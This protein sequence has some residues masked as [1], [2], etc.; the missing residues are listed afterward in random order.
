[1]YDVITRIGNSIVQH[2]SHNDRIYVMK[3]S[4]HDIPDIAHRLYDMAR[5]NRYS[6]VFVK[7]PA[8]ALDKFTNAGYVIEA[9]IPGFFN[10][11]EGSYFVANYLDRTREQE[12]K[13]NVILN[14]LSTARSLAGKCKDACLREG[15]TLHE[16]VPEDSEEIAG[17]YGKVFSTYPFPVQDPVYIRKSIKENLKYYC[18]RSKNKLVAA[19]SSDVDVES[20]NVELTD[21]A[22]LP[23]YRGIGLSTYLLQKMEDDMKEEFSNGFFQLQAFVSLEPGAHEFFKSR[24]I[25]DGVFYLPFPVIPLDHGRGRVDLFRHLRLFE[26]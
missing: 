4:T 10:G 15:F 24:Y 18:I 6:K 21:F 3:L 13:D 20:N 19:A 2:G 22:T 26:N 14:V 9:Y 17:L 12:K 25:P 23:E 1:M 7:V 11:N 5:K 8:F 16:A